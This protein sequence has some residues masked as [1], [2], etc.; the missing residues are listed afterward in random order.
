M[1]GDELVR[2]GTVAVLAPALGQHELFLR[3][4]HREPPDFFQITGKTAFSGHD[5]QSRSTGHDSALLMFA[6]GLSGRRC[7]QPLPEPTAPTCSTAATPTAVQHY[8]EP[9]GA[10]GRKTV[11]H[12]RDP[13]VTVVAPPQTP[14]QTG[15]LR[16]LAQS[17]GG[18]AVVQ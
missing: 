7:A 4:Q 10:K 2:G 6:P 13:P 11:S 14:A 17:A 16:T 3:F 5:R 18:Q 1:A 9:N 15:V 8:N 12:P